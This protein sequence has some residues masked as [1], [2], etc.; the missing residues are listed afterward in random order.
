MIYNLFNMLLDQLASV[1]LR[2][3]ASIFIGYWLIVLPIFLNFVMPWCVIKL[4]WNVIKVLGNMVWK[5]G[6]GTCRKGRLSGFFFFFLNLLISQPA[7]SADSISFALPPLPGYNPVLI[8]SDIHSWLYHWTQ[9]LAC[10]MA[11]GSEP[12]DSHWQHPLCK[13][14]SHHFSSACSAVTQ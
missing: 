2:I 4:C 10:D 6:D 12:S 14:P 7:N 13:V 5:Q 3:S 9:P 8:P 11:M 1:L